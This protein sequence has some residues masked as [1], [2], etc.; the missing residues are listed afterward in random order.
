MRSSTSPEMSSPEAERRFTSSHEEK[1][2][3][4]LLC[5]VRTFDDFCV[6]QLNARSGCAERGSCFPMQY[7]NMY[8]CIVQSVWS[9][10]LLTQALPRSITSQLYSLVAAHCHSHTLDSEQTAFAH[11]QLP[12]LA[13]LLSYL[14]QCLT[15]SLCI[16][17]SQQVHCLI[18]HREV[19]IRANVA[20]TSLSSGRGGRPHRL[21]QL[22]HQA[23]SCELSTR[24]HTPPPPLPA[25]PGRA[26]SLAPIQP[27]RAPTRTAQQ[28]FCSHCS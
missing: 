3:H 14:R 13:S 12:L 4:C 22:D 21:E 5:G 17:V 19:Q 20:T 18:G 26:S 16:L 24:L 1:S 27:P 8:R 2:T 15:P 6:Q 7:V 23:T 9:L 10:L 11:Q 28:S 25:Y